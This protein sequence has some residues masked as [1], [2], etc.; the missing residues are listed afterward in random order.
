MEWVKELAI[1]TPRIWDIL[2]ENQISS[3]YRYMEK[4]P[5]FP[6]IETSVMTRHS[7]IKIATATIADTIFLT[8]LQKRGKSAEPIH[9]LITR[10]HNLAKNGY[11]GDMLK[12]L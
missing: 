4:V 11:G 12:N 5:S 9:P 3:K 6:G 7:R 8:I 2:S 1:S 10:K